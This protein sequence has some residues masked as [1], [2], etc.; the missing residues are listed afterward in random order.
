METKG[1]PVDLIY[2]M[3][4]AAEGYD[5]DDLVPALAVLLGKV[6]RSVCADKDVFISF[7]I[8]VID[9]EY[10]EKGGTLQ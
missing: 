9:E 7:V 10:D 3:A 8:R 4:D 6:G 1:I 2:K 5:V